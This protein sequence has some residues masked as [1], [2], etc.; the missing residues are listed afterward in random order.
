MIV[1]A[2]PIVRS[3]TGSESQA[4]LEANIVG[5]IAYSLND[6]VD[7]EPIHYVYDAPWIFG[8]TSDGAKLLTLSQ[9][10]WCAM[11]TDEVRGLYDWS[12]VVVKGPFTARQSPFA[13]W[14]Y[15]R[16]LAALR[17]LVPSALTDEDPTPRRN[18]VF[19]IHATEIFGRCSTSG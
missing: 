19:G 10:Q 14:D 13:S 8:R 7:V 11:E 18:V 9:N 1:Q 3:M 16:A 6:R 15:E 17:R 5:R 12:S 2:S 4:L